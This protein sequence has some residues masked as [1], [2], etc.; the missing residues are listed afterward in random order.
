MLTFRD[1]YSSSC[2]TSPVGDRDQ[3]L[4]NV[5]SETGTSQS[6]LS[7]L[8]GVHQPSVSQILS[9]KIDFSDEQ[10]DRLLSGMGYRLEVTRHPVKPDLTRS[11]YRSWKLHRFLSTELNRSTLQQWRPT[12][13]QNMLRL[14]DR[15]TGQPHQRNLRHWEELTDDGDVPG[16]RRIL[17]GLDRDSIEMREVSPMTGLISQ[18]ERRKILGGST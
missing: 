18:E 2:Y 6:E 1:G 4:R 10:L 8:S 3:I 5:M 14:R 9:G 11:E 7:R 12:I 16:L 15:V 13:S 17:I